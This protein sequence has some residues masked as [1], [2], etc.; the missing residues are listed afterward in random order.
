MYCQS[1]QVCGTMEAELIIQ[2]KPQ[3]CSSKAEGRV[4]ASY[5]PAMVGNGW[6][7][8]QKLVK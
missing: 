7:A 4:Y 3:V 1:L 8:K 5:L 6:D 2:S